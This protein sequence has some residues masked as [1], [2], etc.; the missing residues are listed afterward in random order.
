MN[1]DL[2]QVLMAQPLPG[3][4]LDQVGEAIVLDVSDTVRG[5]VEV[6]P[7]NDPFQ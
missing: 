3:D 2:P 6:N 7:V 4:L 1:G 5:G